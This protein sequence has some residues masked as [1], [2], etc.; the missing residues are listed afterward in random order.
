[1]HIR[2]KVHFIIMAT[3]NNIGKCTWK[4]PIVKT[5]DETLDYIIDNKCSVS[6]F[7]DGEFTVIQ[8]NGNGLQ[9]ADEKLGEKLA[10]ILKSNT[11]NHIVCISDVFGDLGYMKE[12][13]Y[14]F[15]KGLLNTERKAW[16]NLLN[17]DKVYYNAFFTRSYNMFRDKS[18]CG[19]WF[20]KI[21]KIWEN[22]D[23]LYVE[24]EKNKGG[25][26]K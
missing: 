12:S 25:G 6:R 20:E 15:H 9:Y 21:K 7:G 23:V 5:I 19:Q 22:E 18:L 10:H 4:K 1:M 11:E 16:L 17:K 14:I 8:G 24:G 13:S 26:R 3:Y 2:E